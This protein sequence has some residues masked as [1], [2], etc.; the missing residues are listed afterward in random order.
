MINNDIN[1]LYKV[2]NNY[3]NE[4]KNIHSYYQHWW[5]YEFSYDFQINLNK[6]NIKNTIICIIWYEFSNDEYHDIELEIYHCLNK[7]IIDENEFYIDIDGVIDLNKL[8]NNYYW[9]SK[10]SY[11]LIYDINNEVLLNK[12]EILLWID[13]INYIKDFFQHNHM[14][15]IWFYKK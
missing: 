1:T 10:N 7:V 5:C 15:E 12:D 2:Y 13:N 3:I 14:K 11:I 8:L 6:N 4:L 9:Y